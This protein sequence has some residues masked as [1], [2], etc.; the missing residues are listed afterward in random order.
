MNRA[1]LIESEGNNKV[2]LFITPETIRIND[3]IDIEEVKD[4][5]STYTLEIKG[6]KL[7][8][9]EFSTVWLYD[10][11]NDISSNI[12]MLRE[13]LSNRVK[14]N[15]FEGARVIQNLFIETLNIEIINRD[16]NKITRAKASLSFKQQPIT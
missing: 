2:S 12:N 4:S 14:L 5:G 1:Y 6:K 8:S 7:T 16:D 3:S 13:M 10:G 15:Y 9:V 11:G